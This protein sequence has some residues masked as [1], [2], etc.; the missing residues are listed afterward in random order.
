MVPTIIRRQFARLRWRERWVR[1]TWGAACWLAVAA[2]AL[3][4]ACGTDWV[5]DRREET[6]HAVRRGLVIAQGV[7]WGTAALL[8]L[9]PALLRWLS[10]SRLALWVEERVPEFD[11]R[12]ISAVQLNQPDANTRGMSPVLIRAVTRE[13]EDQAG[14]T[15]FAGLVDL[16]RL[17]WGAGLVAGVLLV[18]AGAFAA[19][20]ET[21]RALLARQLGEDREIPRKVALEAVQDDGVT[22]APPEVVRPAREEVVLRFRARGVGPDEEPVGEA[23]LQ[24]EGGREKITLVRERTLADGDSIWL[25]RV[26]APAENFTY[27]AW[28]GDG[29]TRKSYNV[30]LEPRP[31]VTAL[32]A[33]V[34]LPKDYAL[35]P[36]TFPQRNGDVEGLPLATATVTIAIQE[37]KILKEAYLDVLGRPFPRV[38]AYLRQPAAALPG[39]PLGGVAEA[40]GTVAAVQA[41]D[42][43]GSLEDTP[44]RS[45]LGPEWWVQEPLPFPTDGTSNT[46]THRFELRPQQTGYRVRVRD[47]FGFENL[48]PPRRHIRLLTDEP[49]KVELL[50]ERFLPTAVGGEETEVEGMPVPVDKSV[51]IAYRCSDGYGLASAGP[52]R[53]AARLLYRVLKK[54]TD[55]VAVDETQVPWRVFNLAEVRAGEDVGR[56]DPDRGV[57]ERTGAGDQIEYY[58]VPSADPEH[59]WG[60]LVGGGR[61]DFQTKGLGAEPGDQIEL[62]VEVLDGQGQVGRSESRVKA[63]VTEDEFVQWVVQTLEQER[64]IRKLEEN[65]RSVFDRYRLQP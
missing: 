29:R 20:P 39:A 52:N 42:A 16:R 12:L 50:A 11:H 18:A 59:E 49:P 55:P 48:D 25:A 51:R 60:R 31:V 57:F 46:A 47:Q 37:G 54:G 53:P 32:E 44:G 34:T 22:E 36:N 1:L 65:Q 21:T 8:F 38:L 2:L 9:L 62:L 27:R 58:A 5:L 40:A 35:S 4:L 17:A 30:R 56:F 61:F 14:R 10:D 15:S 43:A 63:V 3:T 13:A 7:L 64:R 24:A 45:A 26:P 28:L 6:P 41:L 19:F 33:V 23:R